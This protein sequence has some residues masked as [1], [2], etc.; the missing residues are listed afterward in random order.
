MFKRKH[1][2]LFVYYLFINI[3][4]VYGSPIYC[5][6]TGNWDINDIIGDNNIIGLGSGI[7]WDFL[8]GDGETCF[9]V[10]DA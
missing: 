5:T 3:S 9:F 7:V 1:V 2:H 10:E 6:V 8:L 4:I